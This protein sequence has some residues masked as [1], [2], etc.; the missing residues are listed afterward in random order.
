MDT[1]VNPNQEEISSE[2]E[3]KD[4][5]NYP[6]VI[7]GKDGWYLPLSL[8][9][10][11]RQ[12]PRERFNL[13]TIQELAQSIRRN[14]LLQ[15]PAVRLMGNGKY[16]IIFGERRFR[17][18]QWLSEAEKDERYKI[19]RVKIYNILAA[20]AFEISVSEN[21][22]RDNLNPIEEARCC[23]RFREEFNYTFERIAKVM[24]FSVPTVYMRLI[25]LEFAEEVG[26]IQIGNERKP[27]VDLV[28]EGKIPTTHVPRLMQFAK[29]DE[30]K[31]AAM[32]LIPKMVTGKMPFEQAKAELLDLKRKRLEKEIQ[33][34]ERKPKSE[35][36]I[37][38]VT[39]KGD[40]ATVKVDVDP[41]LNVIK[42]IHRD[43]ELLGIYLESAS[44]VQVV[45]N[46]LKQHPDSLILRAYDQMDRRTIRGLSNRIGSVFENLRDQ[47]D[48]LDL[49]RV[50]LKEE[51]NNTKPEGG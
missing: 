1:M 34:E 36:P 23:K 3:V 49:L 30:D 22:D 44:K 48:V 35:T 43:I 17:A 7:K 38:D 39:K 28:A 19:M 46:R 4:Y 45:I 11:N 20:E 6:G 50:D 47:F 41:D 2:K 42:D 10:P 37:I 24:G 9:V 27:L 14:G 15:T 12:Q 33:E 32:A 5:Q 40:V 31:K 18:H 29:N 21:R 51:D 16:E 25:L 8:I 26:E 13:K